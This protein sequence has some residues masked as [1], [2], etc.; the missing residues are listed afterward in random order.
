MHKKLF[1]P[2]PTEVRQEILKTQSKWMIGHRTKEFSELYHNCITK[3]KQVLNTN[4]HVMWFTSSGTGIM[5]GAIRNIV[6]GKILHCTSGAF[7]ER[8]FNISKACGKDAASIGVEWGKAIKPKTIEA[9]LEKGG[10]MAVAITQN[11]TSTGVRQPIEEIAQM[12]HE[13]FPN[14]FILVDAVSGLMGDWF[15]I[16]KLGLDVVVAS[17]QKAV[18]LPP[19]L[20]VAIVSESALEKCRTVPGRGYYFD[21]DAMMKRY[22]KNYQTPTTPAVSLFYALDSELDYILEET[23]KRRY[24]RH[25]EMAKFTRAW[26]KQHFALFAEPGY[27]SVTLTSVKNTKGVNVNNLNAALGEKGMQISNGYGRLKEQTFRIAHMGDL[28]LADM[29]ELAAAIEEI[30]KL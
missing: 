6:D 3:T 18:A 19:G 12:V 14:V 13:K 23:M 11:E 25:L 27:E 7:G 5:E 15:D 10:Y 2:G 16:D 8:W 20:A 22:E 29:K 26:A 30:L 1:I 17:S 4:H 21:Y 24:E 28:M 9:E